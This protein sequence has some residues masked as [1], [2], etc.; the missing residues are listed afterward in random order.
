MQK[1]KI[2]SLEFPFSFYGCKIVSSGYGTMHSVYLG[3]NPLSISVIC[4]NLLSSLAKC[5]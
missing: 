2:K 4:Q 5:I 1:N 3:L